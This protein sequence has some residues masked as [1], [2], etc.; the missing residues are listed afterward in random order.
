MV[1]KLPESN[2]GR[3][4]S[5]LK[6]YMTPIRCSLPAG[7][8]GPHKARSGNAVWGDYTSPPYKSPHSEPTL[9]PKGWLP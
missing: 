4:E 5:W 3:C 9:D 7:H 1:A 8:E 6:V 2:V